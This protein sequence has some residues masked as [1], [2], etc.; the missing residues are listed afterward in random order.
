MNGIWKTF[1]IYLPFIII[2]MAFYWMISEIEIQYPKITVNNSETIYG[3]NYKYKTTLIPFIYYFTKEGRN[4]QYGEK[5]DAAL[6]K[7]VTR[8][9]NIVIDVSDLDYDITTMYIVYEGDQLKKIY[10]GEY[11]K[12]ITNYLIEPGTYRIALYC[13]LH[14]FLYYDGYVDYKFKIEVS[15]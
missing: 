12:D 11:I 4:Q 9:G 14:K 8:S 15:K 1:F 5:T 13:K 7:K 10:E 3:I 6:A 2:L